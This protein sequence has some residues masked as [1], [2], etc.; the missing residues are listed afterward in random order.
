MPPAGRAA[1][2][3]PGTAEPA[4][5]AACP[6]RN[7]RFPGTALLAGLRGHPA[8]GLRPTPPKKYRGGC[9]PPRRQ[10]KWWS[11][12]S[13]DSLAWGHPFPEG[14]GGEKVGALAFSSPIRAGRRAGPRSPAASAARWRPAVARPCRPGGER[15]ASCPPPHRHIISLFVHS[16]TYVFGKRHCRFSRGKSRFSRFFGLCRHSVF[17]YNSGPGRASGRP[18]KAL[19]PRV[20]ETPA[21]PSPQ[22]L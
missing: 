13:A 5:P 3:R 15:R 20:R 18:G 14:G 1:A 9:G 16:Y 4:R 12:R 7:P 17:W 21:G 8:L 22:A 6:L 19:A 10:G 11:L 2:L